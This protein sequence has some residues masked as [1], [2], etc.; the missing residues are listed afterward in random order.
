MLEL[1]KDPVV[2]ARAADS[3]SPEPIR[4]RA[5]D[6]PEVLD[7]NPPGYYYQAPGAE[8]QGPFQTHM[9]MIDHASKNL[10]KPWRRF[11]PGYDSAEEAW[12]E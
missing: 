8:A 9:D 3:V 6:S 12:G 7:G 4:V 5:S 11:I 2:L 1:E 10:P